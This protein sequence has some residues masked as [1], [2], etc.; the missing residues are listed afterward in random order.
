[1]GLGQYLVQCRALLNDY[2]K[3]YYQCT[4]LRGDHLYKTYERQDK[5]HNKRIIFKETSRDIASDAFT[6]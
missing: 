1:M 3:A 4:T 6:T 2:S 5:R